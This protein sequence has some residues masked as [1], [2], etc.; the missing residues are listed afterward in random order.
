MSVPVDAVLVEKRVNTEKSKKSSILP[1]VGA[2]N[3]SPE[4]WANLTSEEKALV[5]KMREA[6]RKTKRGITALGRGLGGTHIGQE[7]KTQDSEE[8][9]DAE[10]ATGL[11]MKKRKT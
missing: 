7:S 11:N 10:D 2:R 4:E 8:D 1:R 5:I 3:Y 6:L 9:S